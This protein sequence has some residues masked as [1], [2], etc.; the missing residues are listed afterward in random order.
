MGKFPGGSR[1]KSWAGENGKIVP[2]GKVITLD[3]KVTSIT[4]EKE[5]GL[6]KSQKTGISDD[7]KLF[8]LDKSF[9]AERPLAK[10]PPAK[11]VSPDEII[12]IPS[13]KRPR[14]IKGPNPEYPKEALES[15]IQ[16][17]V[18][19]EAAAN[20]FG[21]V[22]SAKAIEGPEI[23]R[24]AAEEAIKK[25]Q[26]EPYLLDGVPRPV[27]FTVVVKFNLHNKKKIQ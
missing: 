16:G 6:E 25:W 22:V 4:M 1:D 12:K 19:I 10:K 7:G 11:K 8:S 27:K 2:L 5:D 17:N 14:L 23:L 15:Q 21:R 9:K 13:L 3:G 26:Y 24:P 18:T 20:I